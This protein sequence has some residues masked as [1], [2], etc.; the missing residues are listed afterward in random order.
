MGQELKYSTVW[1]ENGKVYGF[2]QL[3]NPGPSVLY[4]LGITEADL[5]EEVSRVSRTE[6]GTYKSLPVVRRWT[7]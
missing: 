5:K 1:I 4:D 6:V 2:V 3:I 7:R